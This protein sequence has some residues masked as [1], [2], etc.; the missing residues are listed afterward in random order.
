M[1]CLESSPTWWLKSHRRRVPACFYLCIL[2]S[3]NAR[4]LLQSMNVVVAVFVL[5]TWSAAAYNLFQWKLRRHYDLWAPLHTHGQQQVS[6]GDENA[7]ASSFKKVTMSRVVDEKECKSRLKESNSGSTVIHHDGKKCCGIGALVR[8]WHILD[9]NTK[10]TNST[11]KS[12]K[13]N[14]YRVNIHRIYALAVS[15][16]IFQSVKW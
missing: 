11:L 6:N 8:L 1:W 4:V 2:Y 12:S 9:L 14:L 3:P 16:L 7:H 15:F 10:S 5:S 13:S